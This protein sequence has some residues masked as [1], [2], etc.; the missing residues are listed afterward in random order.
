MKQPIFCG[1]DIVDLVGF[2]IVEVKSD[3]LDM[4]V[5]I[6]LVKES[7]TVILNIDD[8]VLDGEKME[9]TDLNAQMAM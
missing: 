5:R 7:E 9:I 1:Q 6:K 2:T 8:S 3:D 4:N